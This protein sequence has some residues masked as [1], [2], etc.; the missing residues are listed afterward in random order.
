MK[1]SKKITSALDNK[2]RPKI[3]KSRNQLISISTHYTQVTTLQFQIGV[4][5]YLPYV[6]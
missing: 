4:Q 6:P 3:Q 2:Y 1:I 5:L